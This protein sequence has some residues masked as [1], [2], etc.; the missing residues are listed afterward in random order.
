VT[1]MAEI[2]YYLVKG[3]VLTDDRPKNDMS[4]YTIVS[5]DT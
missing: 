1:N 2:V 5:N 4:S 3:E